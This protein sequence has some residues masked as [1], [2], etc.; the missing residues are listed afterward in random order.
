MNKTTKFVLIA[1]AII[2]SHGTVIEAMKSHSGMAIASPKRAHTTGTAAI[3]N[4][5]GSKPQ[6]MEAGQKAAGTW[7]DPAIAHRGAL[8]FYD[9]GKPYYEFTNFYE[10][11]NS[12]LIDG[13]TWPT[14][15]QYYQAI[16]FAGKTQRKDIM[17][18]IRTGE[19]LTNGKT[20]KPQHTTWG[21]WAFEV[22]QNNKQ[23]IRADWFDVSTRKML[24]ALR[25]KFQDPRLRKM[26]LKTYPR[27]LVEDSDKDGYFG[28]GDPKNANGAIAQGT[29]K[30]LLGRMLMHIRRELHTGKKAKFDEKNDFS[31]GY[32]LNPTNKI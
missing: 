5:K 24:K 6:H 4:T 16:K 28:V 9:S 20:V 17:H 26:L 22:A 18:L 29:G 30:N 1:G 32:L 13:F 19:N 3:K 27:V 12:L 7:Y 10:M 21:S 23:L 31:L 11:P 14:S 8:Y 2:A 15:E 25:V